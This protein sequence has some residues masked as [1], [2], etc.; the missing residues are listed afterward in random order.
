MGQYMSTGGLL[1]GNRG[2]VLEYSLVPGFTSIRD[3]HPDLGN[4]GTA[5]G[6]D[7]P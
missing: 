2:L 5:S 1:G 3:K 7:T 6:K 4:K